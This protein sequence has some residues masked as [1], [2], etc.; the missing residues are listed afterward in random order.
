MQRRAPARPPR[1]APGWGPP[2][3]RRLTESCGSKTDGRARGRPL[4]E[5]GLVHYRPG[6]LVITLLA[7]IRIKCG[8][9]AGEDAPLHICKESGRGEALLR[10]LEREG[11]A[12]KGRSC[13]DSLNFAFHFPLPAPCA[14]RERGRI[15]Q[16]R[17]LG[18]ALSKA[19][20][21]PSSSDVSECFSNVRPEPSNVSPGGHS[22]A[23]V[24]G[25]S[26]IP[27]GS[28]HV[29]PAEPLPGFPDAGR[30]SRSSAS[31]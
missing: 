2:A 6:P 13:D 29:P 22:P 26:Q 25:V 23:E 30:E 7:Q 10:R 20:C 19:T 9:R 11:G 12:R 21:P 28:G 31:R 4:A 15:P 1:P 27:G 5:P 18:Q 14:P 17:Q 8:P 16:E 3:P 24:K